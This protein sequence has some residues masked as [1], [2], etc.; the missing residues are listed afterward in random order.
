[1]PNDPLLLPFVGASDAHEAQWCVEEL[2]ERHARPI[3][4]DIVQRKVRR[5]AGWGDVIDA[6]EDVEAD[7]VMQLLAR[8]RDLRAGHDTE[9]IADFASYA[10][11]AAY[12]GCHRYVRALYPLRARLK[13]RIRYLLARHETFTIWPGSRATQLC[14]RHVWR[15]RDEEE[16][17]AAA[18]LRE[19]RDRPD[20]LDDVIAREHASSPRDGRGA[21]LDEAALVTVILAHVAGPIDLDDLCA[22]VA[23]RL[24]IRDAPP[25]APSGRGRGGGRDEEKGTDWE[26]RIPDAQPSVVTTL[27][28]GERLRRLWQELL[29]LPVRQRAALLLNLRDADGHGMI[30]TLPLTGVA[31]MREIAAAL[32]MP[33]VEFAAL[34]RDLPLED[35]R[36]AELLAI[37]RQQVINLRKC[38]RERLARRLR[39]T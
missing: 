6:A 1:M 7:V 35:R 34:W 25:S 11:V 3:V 17:E 15:G 38:A 18:R 21:P 23:A 31:T 30:A 2:I 36:I 12:H 9:P 26:A 20:T 37:T 8:L 39:G 24:G 32:E 27:V 14:G 13:N 10:A 29:Q 4:R 22:V 28:D 5:R 16:P 33:A 19:I